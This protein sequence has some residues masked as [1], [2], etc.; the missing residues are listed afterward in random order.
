MLAGRRHVGI[1]EH[2]RSDIVAVVDGDPWF[3]PSI[4]SLLEDVDATTAALHVAGLV[5]SIWEIVA[6]VTAWADY[7]SDRFDG[8][9]PGSPASGDWPAVGELDDEHWSLATTRLRESHARLAA[10]IESLGDDRMLEV[11]PGSPPDADG[12]P[13]TIARLTAGVAQHGAYH[14]GQIAQLRKL[15]LVQKPVSA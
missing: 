4:F 10:M 3:G 5:H 13:L 1:A 8:V 11:L 15:A 12:R 2:I 7:V 14:T 6:H 9:P